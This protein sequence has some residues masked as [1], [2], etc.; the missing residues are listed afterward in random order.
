ML[1]KKNKVSPVI[2]RAHMHNKVHKG[3]GGAP[4]FQRKALRNPEGQ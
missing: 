4:N 2:N 1:I 3:V